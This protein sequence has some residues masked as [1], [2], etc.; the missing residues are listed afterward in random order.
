MV[1]TLLIARY[2]DYSTCF[3]IGYVRVPNLVNHKNQRWSTEIEMAL[4]RRAHTGRGDYA[5]AVTYNKTTS[6]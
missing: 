6:S 3:H 1:L 5:N 4:L 2:C